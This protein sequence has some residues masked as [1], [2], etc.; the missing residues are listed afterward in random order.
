MDRIQ[1]GGLQDDERVDDDE[2]GDSFGVGDS[3]GGG[4]FG[5]SGDTAFTPQP[6]TSLNSS[7]GQ[8]NV[9]AGSYSSPA[10]GS[11]SATSTPSAAVDESPK[12]KPRF[13]GGD[14]CPRCKKT[15]YFAEARDGPNNIKY[16]KPCFACAVCKKTLDSSFTER[17]GE[18]YCKG[19]YAKE[20]GPKTFG[21]SPA[22]TTEGTPSPQA[23]W[24]ASQSPEVVKR[25]YTPGSAGSSGSPSRFGGGEKCPRC[26]KTVYAAEAKEGP[27]NIKYHRPCFT[28]MACAKTLDSHFAERQGDLYCKPCY[29]KLYGPKGFGIGA[30]NVTTEGATPSPQ[31]SW[32]TSQSPESVKRSYTPGSAGSSSSISSRFGGGDKCPRCKKTVYFA[33]AKEGPN[34]I[35]Y[36]RPCFT[37]MAC[38]KTLDSHFSQHQEELYCKPCY[39]KLY[40]PKGFGF[41]GTLT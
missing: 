18:I 16:H 27:N 24:R 38:A 8:M 35:K 17:Q 15:V 32:R 39:G 41:G 25:A 10:P 1:I 13:G 23:S 26:Q 5:D 34:N 12:P 28:C 2:G 11:Y 6:E 29:N 3:Y 22:S 33:E 4:N 37:C 30:T 14:V 20:F 36:H 7:F 9:S 31:A 19:C 40:G 21:F